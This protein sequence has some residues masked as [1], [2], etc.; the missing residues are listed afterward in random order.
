M[1]PAIRSFVQGR[2]GS[3]AGQKTA[4]VNPATEEVVAEVASDVLD[5]AACLEYARSNGGT[6]LREMSFAQRGQLLDAVAKVLHAAREELLDIATSNGGNTRGD[7]KFDVDG[8]IGTLS[9]YGKLGAALGEKHLLIDG[10]VEQLSRSPRFVGQHIWSPLQGA[11]LHINAFNFPAW[12]MME[13]AAVAWL[14]GMPVVTKPAT[15]TAHVAHRMVELI[16]DAKV[17]PAG[18]LSFVAGSAANLLDALT[19]QDVL[20]FTGS[21]GTALKLRS[22]Q[23]ILKHNVRVN[24]EADSL[25]A[26]VLGPDVESSSDTF[27]LF[28][29][30][31][32]RDMTQKAGQKCTAIRRIFVKADHRAAASEALAEGLKAVKVGDPIHSE[33]RMGPVANADQLRDVQQ[34]IQRIK[35][36]GSFVYGDGGRGPLIGVANNKGYFVGP[37]L[38]AIDTAQA[39]SVVHSHEVFGPVATLIPYNGTAEDAARQ[40][41]LGAGGLVSSVYTDDGEF[42]TSMVKQASASLGRLHLGSS[43][44]AE[45]SLGP[46]A[47]LPQLQHGGP[48]RAGGGSELGGRRGM[49]F[50]MQ[51]TAIQGFAPVLEKLR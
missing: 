12:G 3:G 1:P 16:V 24:V 6:A 5:A 30:E 25:N 10:E 51:R 31:V 35:Q 29:R 17:L 4:L 23:N 13:K 43:K 42:A 47:V 41:R 44:I 32:V 50:Y 46:G 34:G 37:T 38:L 2:W 11:A 21:S 15:S 39:N 45:H 28:V 19:W 18:V 48:G 26:A 8:A 14:S 27:D 33:V 20:A 9:Y 7:G 49:E 36:E 22:N 40:I